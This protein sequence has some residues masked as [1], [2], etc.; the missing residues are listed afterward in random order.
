MSG[1]SGILCVRVQNGNL[2]IGYAATNEPIKLIY[3]PA[4]VFEL[5]QDR[6][7]GELTF[8]VGDGSAVL[9]DTVSVHSL[10]A[11]IEITTQDYD[12][13]IDDDIDKVKPEFGENENQ[14]EEKKGC[15]C[16]SVASAESVA[17]IV[18]VF[19]ALTAVAVLRRTKREEK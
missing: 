11:E 6:A 2:S 5:P 16:G 4:A 18:F 17:G 8:S 7:F 14:A 1:E 9:L 10:D 12:P 3:E 19:A 15:G 13:N